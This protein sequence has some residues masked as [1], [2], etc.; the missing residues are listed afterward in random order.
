MGVI[1]HNSDR[2]LSEA[3]VCIQLKRLLFNTALNKTNISYF[4]ARKMA[5]KIG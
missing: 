3:E 2:A 4:T 1:T 5:A